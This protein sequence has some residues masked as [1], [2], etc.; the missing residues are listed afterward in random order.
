MKLITKEVIK[1]A[2]NYPPYSQ[3]DLGEDSIV[4]LKFFDPCG[5]YTLYVTEANLEIGEFF[6]YCVS[7][8]G[9]DCDEWGY[10]YLAELESVVGR[11]GLGIERDMHW[12]PV[13][14]REALGKVG[15]TIK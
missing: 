7:A 3:E 8:L 1:A 11:F 5:R 10:T 2:K 12:K 4:W 14:I 13:T 15:L 9:A 6:G